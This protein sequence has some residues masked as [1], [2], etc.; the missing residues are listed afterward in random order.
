MK[1][2]KISKTLKCSFYFY[3]C[4][5]ACTFVHVYTHVRMDSLRDYFRSPGWHFRL[6]E[7]PHVGGGNRAWVLCKNSE[8]SLQFS[9]LASPYS[10]FL[11]L[12][13]DNWQRQLKGGK[14]YFGSQFK[15]RQSTSVRTAAVM[16]SLVLTGICTHNKSAQLASLFLFF[17]SLRLQP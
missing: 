5:F 11:L 12:W 3:T 14:D 1:F 6:C 13:P 7:P 17:S 4:V 2:S 9:Q 16:W 15:G 10:L 8:S